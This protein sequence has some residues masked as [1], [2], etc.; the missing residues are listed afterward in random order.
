MWNVRMLDFTLRVG[1][2]ARLC[3][4]YRTQTK[5]KVGSG[6]KYVRR[7]RWPSMRFTDDAGL[8][9]QALE[10]CDAVANRRI[11]GTTHRVPGEMLAEERPH[12]GK[13]PGRA[14]MAPYLRE[15][16]RGPGTASSAQNSVG[17]VLAM[18]DFR[19]RGMGFCL[20]P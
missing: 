6:V 11:H 15:D 16:R 10:W 8:N 9:R 19:S 4:P 2:E 5:G 1:F 18:M 17:L 3:Q 13:L 7:N 12:L 14:A 20:N